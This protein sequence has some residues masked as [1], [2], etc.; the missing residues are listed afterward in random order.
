VRD[1]YFDHIKIHF[2]VDINA[3]LKQALDRSPAYGSIK[4]VLQNFN[5]D[6]V[7]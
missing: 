3:I 2:I 4:D 6:E 1:F 5:A 7:N